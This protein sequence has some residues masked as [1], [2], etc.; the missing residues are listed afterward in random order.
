MKPTTGIDPGWPRGF[1][2]HR[3]SQAG[4]GLGMTPAERLRWLEDTMATLR[5]WQGLAR[6]ALGA[7]E[8]PDGDTSATTEKTPR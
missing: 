2:E 8:R 3:R 5:R 6:P 4:L 7:D 1:A